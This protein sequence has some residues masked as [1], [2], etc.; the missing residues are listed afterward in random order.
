M[1]FVRLVLIEFECTPQLPKTWPKVS[2]R[3]IHAF[4][5]Q[6]NLEI[7]RKDAD[8]EVVVTL[9]DEREIYRALKTEGTTHTICLSTDAVKQ[10]VE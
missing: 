3:N 10:D 9:A 4:A 6:W 7:T 8:V 5:R 1:V 2:F